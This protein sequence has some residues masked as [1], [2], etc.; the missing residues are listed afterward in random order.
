VCCSVLQCVAVC[1]S[2]LQCVAVC[3]RVFHVLHCVAVCCCVSQCVAVWVVSFL[4]QCG[5]TL[6]VSDIQL[7]ISIDLYRTAMVCVVL[8]RAAVCCSVLRCVAAVRCRP[9]PISVYLYIQ[10]SFYLSIHLSVHL[11]YIECE[12]YTCFRS[13]AVATIGKLLKIIRLFCKIPSFL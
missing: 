13:H 2:M 8:Q 1:C 11:E 7:C 6:Y 9:I 12:L 4:S 3:C 5:T 10:P